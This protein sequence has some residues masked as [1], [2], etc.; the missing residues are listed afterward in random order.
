MAGGWRQDFG[1]AA[2]QLRSFAASLPV[3]CFRQVAQIHAE[4]EREGV[5]REVHAV[6]VSHLK[7]ENLVRREFHPRRAAIVPGESGIARGFRGKLV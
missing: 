6:R 7:I 1:F 5:Q 4:T 2:P 3:S